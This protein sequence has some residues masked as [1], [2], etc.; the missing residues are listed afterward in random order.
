MTVRTTRFRQS[1]IRTVLGLAALSGLAM[2]PVES[3]FAKVVE[4]SM[5]A[6]ETKLVIDGEGH[7]YDAWTFNGQ[8]PGPVIRVQEGDEVVFSLTNPETN[9]RPHSMDFHAAKP[10]S[11]N[12]TKE[13]RPGESLRV[14]FQGQVARRICVSLRR[15]SDDPAHRAWHDGAIIV[16]P[17]DPRPCPKADREYVLVQSELFKEPDDVD[18]MFDRKYQHVVFNG[19]VFRYDPVHSKAGGDFLDAKPGEGGSGF[20]S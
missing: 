4:V 9:G 8:F 13:V 3:A 1:V 20:I 7:T 11:W 15:V 6:V 10:I 12:T 19:A 16:D 5:T 14:S 18:G 17:K 2:Q